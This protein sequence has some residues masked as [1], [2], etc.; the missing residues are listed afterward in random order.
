LV[1][2]IIIKCPYCGNSIRVLPFSHVNLSS[3]LSLGTNSLSMGIGLNL[4]YR[5]GVISGYDISCRLCGR[6]YI[7]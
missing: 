6:R 1:K 3:Y 2:E 5:G 4:G 7:L